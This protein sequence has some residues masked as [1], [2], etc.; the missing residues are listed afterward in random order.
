MCS[1]ETQVLLKKLADDASSLYVK[2]I[3]IE[4]YKIIADKSIHQLNNELT[5][6]YNAINKIPR[7]FKK[8]KKD[9]SR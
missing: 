7:I 1:D 5:L 2:D 4:Q 6:N 8:N 3:K 9:V